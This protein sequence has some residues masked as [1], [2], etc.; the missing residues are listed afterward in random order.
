[1][2]DWLIYD[3]TTDRQSERWGNRPAS[4]LYALVV[5]AALDLDKLL[6]QKCVTMQLPL[7]RRCMLFSEGHWGE[8]A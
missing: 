8:V 2:S 3:S 5:L 4:F 1:M 7:S 6:R